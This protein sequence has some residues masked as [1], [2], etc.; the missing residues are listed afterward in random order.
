MRY[1]SIDILRTIAIFIMVFVHFAENLAGVILPLTGLGA[2]LFAFLSG[3][4][5]F[6]WV[7]G[8]QRKGKTELEISKVSVRRGLF[9]FTLGIFFNVLVWLPED[10]FNWDV[11]TCIGF[12]LI[13]LNQGR[14]LPHR[15]LVLVAGAILFTAPVF[16][17]MVDYDAY[18]EQGYYEADWTLVDLLIGFT[19]TGYFPIFPWLS[20]SLLGFVV[21]ASLLHA[22]QTSRSIVPAGLGCILFSLLLLFLGNDRSDLFSKVFLQGWKMFPATTEYVTGTLGVILILFYLLHQQIDRHLDRWKDSPFLALAK[23]FSQ[24]ALTIYVFHH[25]VHLW[26]LWLYGAIQGSETTFYWRQAMPLSTSLVLAAVFL[27]CLTVVLWSLGQR[28]RSGIETWMR[29]L[30]D[31]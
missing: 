8:E 20:Y 23:S 26:P 7:S 19:T 28:Q 10:T 29:W 22:P 1:P 31:D 2:P 24:Y 16:R 30:C 3:A 15:I 5:Y 6:L 21:A 13:V 18:W 17:A 4:S 27:F 11:L 12:A 25:V 9:V 14:R